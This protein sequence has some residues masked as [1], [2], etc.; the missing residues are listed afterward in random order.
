MKAPALPI[1]DWVDE[2]ALRRDFES[3]LKRKLAEGARGAGVK[4]TPQECRVLLTPP[5]SKRARGRPPADWR[6][7][8]AIALDCFAREGRGALP[9]AAVAMT[10]KQF[11]LSHATVWAARRLFDSN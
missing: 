5:H 11:K 1:P 7:T 2:E 8:Y 10:A 6:D 3:A 9:S 4:L